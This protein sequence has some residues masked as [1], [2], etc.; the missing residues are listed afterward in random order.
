MPEVLDWQRATDPRQVIDRAA[1]ALAEGQL[2]AFPTETV[3]GIAASAAVPDAVERLVR[4][5]GRA[6]DKPLAVAVAGLSPALEW[7]PEMGTVGRRLARRC[8]PGP[9]TLVC[10]DGVERGRAA[11]LPENVRRRVCPTSAVGLRTPDHDA[12]LKVLQ[13]VPEPLVLT[14]ANRS[15]APDAAT[16]QEVLDS[17]GEELALVIDDGPSRFRSEER[18]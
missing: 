6:G 3:Y 17:V 14:S 11:R 18:R 1:R 4:S 2:V 15:G 8:W 5:K 9:V 16:P 7:V 10:S 13:Q 12:I